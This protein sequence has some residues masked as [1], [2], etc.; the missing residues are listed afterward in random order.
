M[1]NNIIKNV[2]KNNV[3]IYNIDRSDKIKILGGIL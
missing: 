3:M 1:L 2:G